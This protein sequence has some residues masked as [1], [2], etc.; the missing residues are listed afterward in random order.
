MEDTPKRIDGAENYPA[1]NGRRPLLFFLT[2]IALIFVAA[3]MILYHVEVRRIESEEYRELK[4]IADLKA[5]QIRGWRKERLAASKRSIESPY[6]R[7][8]AEILRNNP[9]ND[10]FRRRM[11]ERLRTELDD[12]TH[13]DALLLA[14]DCRILASARSHSDP[15]DEVERQSIE[16]SLKK[17]KAVLSQFHRS[18]GGRIYIDTVGPVQGSNGEPVAI[19]ML[20]SDPESLLYPLI[21]TWPTLSRTA[22]TLVVRRD[23]NDV[24]FLNNLRHQKNTA[25]S[26]R[27]PLTRTDVPAVQAVL[28][29][30]GFFRGQDYRGAE[31]MAVLLPVPESPWFI[32][33]KVDTAEALSEARYRAGAIC[34]VVFLFLLLSAAVTAYVYRY[35]QAGLYRSL[36]RA[37][38]RQRDA[39]ELFR[40]TLYSIGDGVITTNSSGLV[41]NM[42][43]VAEQLTGWREADAENKPLHD[44]FHIVNETTRKEA[45]NPLDRVLR[46][47]KV[48]GLANHT[49]LISRDGTE[50]PIADSG[51]PIRSETGEIV[52]VV[53]VFRD[54]TQ[55]RT[56]ERALRESEEKYRHLFEH[57]ALGAFRSTLGGRIIAIN[58][59]HARMFGYSSP[60]ELISSV[61]DVSSGLYAD[62]SCRET[63]IRQTEEQ[64]GPVE[65]ECLF[66]RKD[67]TT[68]TGNLHMRIASD[69]WDEPALE[70]FIEDISARKA[71]EE[72]VQA[73]L[74]EKETLLKEIH[75]RVKNNLQIMSSLLN[76]QTQHV[77]DPTALEALRV[78][79]DRMK[80]MALIHDKLYRSETLSSIYLPGYIGDLA[81]GLI[82]AYA[83]GKGVVLNLDV[84]PVAFEIET[85]MPL[86]LI[87]NELVT[88]SLKHGLAAEEGGMIAV[89]LHVDGDEGTLVVSDTGAGLPDGIDFRNAQSMGLQLVL[90]LVEQL[91]GAIDLVRGTGTEFRITFNVGKPH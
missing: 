34:L 80:S 40:T 42:N 20:R 88:N 49:V 31:V 57:A 62:P 63:L 14:P 72:A 41:Q 35:R 1:A 39:R 16:K 70:G 91:D 78:S 15:V 24:L 30:K 12:V 59:A 5:S 6:F 19:L 27:I 50:Y 48:I 82:I 44:V 64:D 61:T 23:G 22:E 18:K 79:V 73:S 52:G 10:R 11:E 84:D 90:I 54:Q 9:H 56:A 68:F 87:I 37:E 71:A 3:G 47:G 74:R 36:Y 43:T 21:N 75:H 45:E 58:A 69:G 85:A 7:E 51:A 33:A 28:G 32:V 81:Q 26:L 60:E 38:R 83:A 65:M 29:V 77:H 86:A 13:V 55:E 8:A 25:I 89:G 4:A 53:L 76:L 17:G 2:A 67:G 46:Q 66:R